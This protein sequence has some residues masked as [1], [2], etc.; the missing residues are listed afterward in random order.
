[1]NWVQLGSTFSWSDSNSYSSFKTSLSENGRVAA[2]G[3]PTANSGGSIEIYEYN[4]VS[5]N[6]LGNTID[7][8]AGDYRIGVKGI[9][10][11]GDGE[12]IIFGDASSNNDT[13]V[14][15]VYNY[16]S[17]SNEWLQ[18]GSDISGEN[19]GDCC[20]TSNTISYDGNTIAIG[21]FNY[22]NNYTNEGRIRIYQWNVYTSS[23][24]QKGSD[25]YGGSAYAELGLGTMRL[26][27][28][29]SILAIGNYMWPYQN[30]RGRVLVYE[31]NNT[32]WVRLG[33]SINGSGV[34]T[35]FGFSLD[36]SDDGKH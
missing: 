9:Q 32:N 17:S 29:G 26:N 16:D 2:I 22:D 21:C 31:W 5:W 34:L 8:S 13:G 18:K 15:R 24:V 10:L 20:G 19:S 3:I 28:D 25:I 14:S 30:Y 35:N 27:K 33:G 12:N 11:S 6:Q 36:L 23:W 4:D 7:S 1:M